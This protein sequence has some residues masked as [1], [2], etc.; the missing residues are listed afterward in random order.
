ML[1]ACLLA[2]ACCLVVEGDARLVAHRSV[3]ASL[4]ARSLVCW[5]V[6]GVAR[7]LL[8]VCSR[9]LLVQL[10]LLVAWLLQASLICLKLLVAQLLKVL[11]VMLLVSA[12]AC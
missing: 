8:K 2:V 9:S 11:L 1:V 6:E 7:C 12:F 4:V 3:L 10:L 5:L